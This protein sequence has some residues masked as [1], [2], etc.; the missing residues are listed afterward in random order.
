MSCADPL[1]REGGW[2]LEELLVGWSRWRVVDRT[3]GLV[4]GRDWK[5]GWGPSALALWTAPGLGIRRSSL[6][7]EG[8]VG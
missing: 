8:A 5:E 7:R 1:T 2:G 4:V 6:G 3:G